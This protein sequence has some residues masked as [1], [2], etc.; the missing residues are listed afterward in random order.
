MSFIKIES[1]TTPPAGDPNE[2]SKRLTQLMYRHV[3][4]TF[5][6]AG[7]GKWKK[8]S[9][10]TIGDREIT[11]YM[12]AEPL[13]R[14]GRLRRSI[15]EAPGREEAVVGVSRGTPYAQLQQFG[16]KII[17]KKRLGSVNRKKDVWA[18]E[19]YFWRRYYETESSIYKYMALKIGKTGN[20]FV[21]ARPYLMITI[22]LKS[23]L[24]QAVK[25]FLN[26]Q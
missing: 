3:M 19:Q 5:D 4:D 25:D 13:Q 15:I 8:L 7:F 14:T 11:N 22:K 20:F 2:L 6:T 17:A 1:V 18:M 12:P 26:G 23:D 9:R 24:I 16:G 10:F 21:T